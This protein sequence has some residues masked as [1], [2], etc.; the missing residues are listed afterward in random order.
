[1]DGA[2]ARFA[3]GIDAVKRQHRQPGRKGARRRGAAQAA[4]EH[5]DAA[6]PAAPFVEIAHDQHRI[7]V[8][9]LLGER[10]EEA[11]DLAAALARA[12]T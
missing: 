7:G 6:A 11:M 2:E 9:R 12:Q 4:V 5:G 10:F 1:M 3:P 8:V